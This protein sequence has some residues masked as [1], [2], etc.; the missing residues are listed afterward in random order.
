MLAAL[1]GSVALTPR[2]RRGLSAAF[3]QSRVLLAQ[4]C[5]PPRYVALSEPDPP[6]P[7]LQFALSGTNLPGVAAF[8]AAS[9]SPSV[10]SPS[11]AWGALPRDNITGRVVKIRRAG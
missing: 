9:T 3:S 6:A 10:A 8:A 7:D 11:S 4:V 2:I 5:E 1:R